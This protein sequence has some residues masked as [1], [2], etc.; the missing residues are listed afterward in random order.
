MDEKVCEK[1]SGLLERKRI[2]I[3]DI[4]RKC[5]SLFGIIMTSWELVFL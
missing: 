5:R 2:S 3:L 4:L 1:S